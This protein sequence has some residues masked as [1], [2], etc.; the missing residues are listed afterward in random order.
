[1][2]QIMVAN[3]QHIRDE[4]SSNLLYICN[5]IV[6]FIH[7]CDNQLIIIVFHQVCIKKSFVTVAANI[8]LLRSE[9]VEKAFVSY[10]ITSK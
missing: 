7:K 6:I 8:L 10:M 5:N 4:L 3:S 2:Y 1:M 9:I